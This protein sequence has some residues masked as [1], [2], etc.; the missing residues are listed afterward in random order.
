MSEDRSTEA[1]EALA[2]VIRGLDRALVKSS[3]AWQEALKSVVATG[4]GISEQELKQALERVQKIQDE[5][6]ASVDRVAQTSGE[7]VAPEMRGVI[8]QATRAGT[9]AGRQTAAT[10]SELSRRFASGSA[11]AA[12]AGMELAGQ[13]GGRFTQI[14]SGVL[15]AMADALQKPPATPKK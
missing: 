15:G 1:R 13:L 12:L 8:D 14:A 4:R 6:I 5:F 10:I 7:R 11:E 9:E 2:E 3:E